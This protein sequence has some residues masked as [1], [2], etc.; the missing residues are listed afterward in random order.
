MKYAGKPYALEKLDV[1]VE[2]IVDLQKEQPSFLKVNRVYVK[3]VDVDMDL[4][5]R[6]D[7]LLSDPRVTAEI[8]A[9]VDF[10]VL[11]KIFPVQEGVTL[12]GSL[13]AG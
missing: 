8:K 9:D 4:S 13:N 10:S 6:V 7:Q 1:D 11:P 2:G 12:T 3:G 5:G